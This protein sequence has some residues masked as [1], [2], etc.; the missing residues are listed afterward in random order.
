MS[1]DFKTIVEDYKPE[2]KYTP[3]DNP[4]AAILVQDRLGRESVIYPVSF[5]GCECSDSF[6]K[7][8]I[9]DC[10]IHKMNCY[11]VVLWEEDF[12]PETEEEQPVSLIPVCNMGESFSINE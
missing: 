5:V 7:G 10:I 2:G 11:F 4:F 8:I 6:R 1:Y 3:L 12:N 9:T